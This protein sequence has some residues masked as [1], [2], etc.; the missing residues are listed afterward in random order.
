MREASC[1]VAEICAVLEMSLSAVFRTGAR[2]VCLLTGPQAV[3]GPVVLGIDLAF[4]FQPG[5]G[6]P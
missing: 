1:T 4:V 2:M 5:E 6:A 3:D